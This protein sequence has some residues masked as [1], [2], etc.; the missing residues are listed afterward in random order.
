MK[1]YIHHVKKGLIMTVMRAMPGNLL[2]REGAPLKMPAPQILRFLRIQCV[3]W[4]F[5]TRFE[6]SRIFLVYRASRAKVSI[7]SKNDY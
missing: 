3:S 4:T 1:T 6:V 7:S 5:M 2:S